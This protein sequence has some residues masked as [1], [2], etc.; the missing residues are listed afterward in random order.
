M[1]MGL[2]TADQLYRIC[3]KILIKFSKNLI[4]QWQSVVQG[5]HACIFVMG[6]SLGSIPAIEVAYQHQN[7]IQ[8]LIIESGS[9]N[10]FRHFFGSSITNYPIWSDESSF[11]NKVKIRSISKPTLI[12][13]AEYDTIVPLKEGKE[14]FENASTKNKSFVV[15]PNAGHNDLMFIGKKRYFKALEKF[16]KKC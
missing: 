7:A 8:G 16:A 2:A 3:L 15:I 9:A 4:E 11:L 1:D 12:I 13:H 14:L 10:N 5:M 6:R